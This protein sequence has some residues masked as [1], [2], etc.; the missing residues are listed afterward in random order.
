[1]KPNLTHVRGER[2]ATVLLFTFCT[3]L[4][5]IPMVGLAIDGSIAMWT[6]AKLSAAVDAAALAAGR[7]LSVSGNVDQEEAAATTVAQKW[8]AANFPSG[9]LNTTIVSGP[10]VNVQQSGKTITASVSAS[11]EA[12][13]FFMRIFGSSF[14]N[15]TV[16]ASAQSSRRNLVLI[17]VLDRSGSM[18]TSGACPI[19]VADAQNFVNYFTDGFDELGLVTFSSS[20]NPNLDYAPNLDFKSSTPTLSSV[21]GQI[22]CTGA[23]STTQALHIAY[24]ALQNVNQPLALNAIV[25]FTDGQPNTILAKNWQINSGGSCTNPLKTGIIPGT[26]AGTIT[27]DTS[28][29]PY[30]IYDPSLYTGMNQGGRLNALS[31]ASTYNATGCRFESSGLQYIGGGGGHQADIASIPSQDYYGNSTSGYQGSASSFSGT[32][33]LAASFNTADNQAYVI[34]HDATLGYPMIFTIGLGSD[35]DSTAQQFL[36]RVA[37]DP[38]ASSYD[39]TIPAGTFVYAP[40]ATQLQTAFYEIAS[41]ILRL[42]Q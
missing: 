30:G 14:Q 15:V 39:S 5:V 29:D 28:N 42:S 13:L 20:A 33:M 4:L 8:F 31:P 40:D 36:E 3:F 34:R 9:W 12:P 6:K 26:I 22:Q 24:T 23:T 2:G 25:L 38:R 27:T 37:N 17:L 19:M 35:V 11:V 16:S 10:T 7:S 21:I 41:E 18:S 32:N 1:M